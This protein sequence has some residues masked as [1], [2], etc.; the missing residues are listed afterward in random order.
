MKKLLSAIL[1]VALLAIML[2]GC[3][4]EK[5]TDVVNDSG[6]Q[7]EETSDSSSDDTESTPDTGKSTKESA[8]FTEGFINLDSHKEVL[9]YFKEFGYV[10]N[11]KKAGEETVPWTFLYQSLGKENIN[12]VDT[13]HIKVTMVEKGETKESEAWYDSEWSAV[14]FINK[15]GEKTGMDA[16]FAGATLT[17]M[18]QLYC[19]TLGI[20]KAIVKEDGTIDEF[21]YNVKGKRSQ[22]ETIDLGAGNMEIELYDV[23]GKIG[24]FDKL[25]GI[26]AL[27]DGKMYVVMET[28]SRD[29][30]TLDGLRVTRAVPR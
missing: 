18:T 26:S 10:Y 15:D 20:F 28:I 13:E 9:K 3:G 12:G 25:Y 29:K 17:M 6:S 30:E 23:E 24:G 8:V 19:N 4:G 11:T 7:V 16:S 1:L 22:N 27:K 5:D 2:T 14:K 21:M